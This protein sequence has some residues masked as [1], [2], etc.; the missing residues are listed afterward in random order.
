MRLESTRNEPR[1][2]IGRAIRAIEDQK[3]ARIANLSADEK[4][5]RQALHRVLDEHQE[6]IF[7]G[8]TE[9]IL[10]NERSLALGEIAQLKDAFAHICRNDRGGL[11]SE[12]MID[13][14]LYAHDLAHA[15][16]ASSNGLRW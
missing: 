6:I 12:Q 3:H 16:R 10:R 11:V 2:L 9:A 1:H 4:A 15:F 14:W 7:T 13:D 5:Q 8:V